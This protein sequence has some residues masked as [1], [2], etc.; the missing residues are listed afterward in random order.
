M[1]RKSKII[2]FSDLHY[3]PKDQ[4]PNEDRKRT[5]CAETMLAELRKKVEQ[6]KPDFV[7]NLGDLIED[8]NDQTKD[9]QNYIYIYQK[10]QN[11]SCPVYSIPGNHDLKTLDSRITL[12]K[13]MG[14]EH[15]TYS[16]S[17]NG[18]HFIF[19]G[20]DLKPYDIINDGGIS[21]SQYISTKDIIWLENELKTS[22]EPCLIFCHYG[23]AE[24]NMENNWWFHNDQEDALLKNRKEIKDLFQTYNNVK[25]VFTGHQH[26]TKKLTENNV[27][28]Y[29]LGSMVES[30]NEN[31]TCDGVYYVVE[32]EPD[33]IC[34]EHHISL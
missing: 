8:C 5:E 26:W 16:F 1:D 31:G 29:I 21:R 28:Y 19:L 13:I 22:K 11:F 20:L 23:I 25:A 17:Y 3:L 2:I 9:I 24:D 30:I 15:S 4:K 18:Y 34:Q 33:F 7:V 6:L 12:E 32:L 10:L 27:S 14:Y